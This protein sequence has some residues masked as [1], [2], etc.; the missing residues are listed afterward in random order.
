[1]AGN[2]EPVKTASAFPIHSAWP[3]SPKYRVCTF[4]CGSKYRSHREGCSKLYQAT[5]LSSALKT[6]NVLLEVSKAKPETVWY[7]KTF[8]VWRLLRKTSLKVTREKSDAI[9]RQ[10]AFEVSTL[11][12]SFVAGPFTAAVYALATASSTL[13]S[14]CENPGPGFVEFFRPAALHVKEAAHLPVTCLTNTSNMALLL[15]S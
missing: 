7:R 3:A 14:V 8:A 10:K 13:N 11:S 5:D 4:S 9:S 1:M 6:G 12:T 15:Y 2:S